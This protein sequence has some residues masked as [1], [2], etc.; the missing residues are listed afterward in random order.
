MQNNY[1]KLTLY[2]GPN[3]T[4]YEHN[5][6]SDGIVKYCKYNGTNPSKNIVPKP[7]TKKTKQIGGF[8]KGMLG[9]EPKCPEGFTAVKRIGGWSCR[10]KSVPVPR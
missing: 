10:G 1:K 4:L 2:L 9:G 3:G 6:N 8:F 5:K 7:K